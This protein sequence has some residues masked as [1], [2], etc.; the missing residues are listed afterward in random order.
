MKNHKVQT[1]VRRAGRVM[2]AFLVCALLALVTL[3]TFWPALHCDFINYDDD[4]YVTANAHVQQGLTQEGVTWA[5]RTGA[6]GNWHPLTWLSLMLDAQLLGHS[7]VGFHLT[8]LLLHIASTV[9]LFLVFKRMTGALWRSAFVAALFALHPL[10]VESV[11]WVAER[12]DVLSAFFFMLTLWAYAWFVQKGSRL[13]YYLALLFF[14][15]G[16]MSKPMLVTL[17]FVLLLLDYWPLQRIN[18]L[19]SRQKQSTAFLRLVCEK[20][21]FFILSTA[22]SIVTFV[23]QQQDKAVQTLS[24]FP[25]GVRFEN[26]VV[27]YSRYLGKTFWP[28]NLAVPYPYPGHW[29]AGEVVFAGVLVVGASWQSLRLA[30]QFPFLLTG[31]FWFVGMLLPVI[32]LVQVG[33]QSMADRYTY[34]PLIGIFIGLTWGISE[35]WARCNFPKAVAGIAAG[36]LLIGCAMQTR[37]QLAYWQNSEILF[38][39]AVAV[40]Q[41]NYAA[42]E[43]LGN[44][45]TANGRIN[46]AIDCYQTAIQMAP[47]RVPA[48]LNL[49]SLFLLAGKLDEAVL[50]YDEVLRLAPDNA[51]AWCNLG[52]ISAVRG[53]F[54]EAVAR[55]YKAIQFKPDF[56]SAYHNLG[57]AF[58]ARGDWGRA[59]QNYR[60]ALQLDPGHA[61]THDH[62]GIALAQ[63]G[64]T[65]EAMNEFNEALRLDPDDSK[66]RQQL[67]ALRQ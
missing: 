4:G 33:I 20:I 18:N 41:D 25:M 49:G 5:F 23:V 22:V 7:A 3:W 10:H 61:S 16:L 63:E 34:L 44:F 28:D 58:A 40:T 67:D 29:P 21:P 31:W 1:Q 9:L 35:L 42:Y 53:N 47:D 50:E 65:A 14:L 38:R 37:A 45:L 46:E 66:A 32:G 6:T 43:H 39:H 60:T 15:F 17:P 59:I 27:S 57:L 26:A 11:A 54:D 13:N 56:S 48:R 52:Y 30:R 36:L 12:K 62:L 24:T 19:D 8:N 64:K 51:D 55:Y 2:P